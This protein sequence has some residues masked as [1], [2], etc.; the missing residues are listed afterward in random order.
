MFR[1]LTVTNSASVMKYCKDNLNF[2]LQL[3]GSTHVTTPNNFLASLKELTGSR[4][5]KSKKHCYFC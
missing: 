1:S 4:G 3:V 5:G 2:F